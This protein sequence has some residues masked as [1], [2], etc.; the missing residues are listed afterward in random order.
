MS[1]KWDEVDSRQEKS[2]QQAKELKQFLMLQTEQAKI[3]QNSIPSI[4]ATGSLPLPQTNLYSNGLSMTSCLDIPSKLQSGLSQN[5]LIMDDYITKLR[6]T[7]ELLLHEKRARLMVDQELQ[8]GKY[9]ILNLNNQL[10][11]LKQQSQHDRDQM[12]QIVNQMKSNEFKNQ[13]IIEKL[14]SKIDNE[15]VKVH[16]LYSEMNSKSNHEIVNQQQKDQNYNLLSE[17]FNQLN[18]KFQNFQNN[19]QLNDSQISNQMKQFDLEFEKYHQTLQH[20]KNY[21]ELFNQLK[22]FID[23]NSNFLKQNIKETNQE[24]LNQINNEVKVRKHLQE[25]VQM[26]QNDLTNYVNNLISE[27]VYQLNKIINQQSLKFK[28]DLEHLTKTNDQNLHS[29][30][31][32]I[33]HTNEPILHNLNQKITSLEI[34]CNDFDQVFKT[35][36]ENLN[37]KIN[38]QMKHFHAQLIKKDEEHLVNI[39][40]IF[41]NFKIFEKSINSKVKSLEDILRIEIKTRKESDSQKY[42]IETETIQSQIIRLNN[43]LDETKVDGIKTLDLLNSTAEKITLVQNNFITNFEKEIEKLSKVIKSQGKQFPEMLHSL[44]VEILSNQ[45]QFEL[46]YKEETSQ[47]NFEIEEQKSQLQ[48]QTSQIEGF[49]NL[50]DQLKLDI[51]DKFKTKSIQLDSTFEAYKIEL[52]NRPTND[53][54]ET[55]IKELETK[56]MEGLEEV[57]HHIEEIQALQRGCVTIGQY[58]ETKDTI[59]TKCTDLEIKSIEVTYDLTQ[60]KNKLEAFHQEQNQIPEKIFLEIQTLDQ[61]CKLHD[62]ALAS[63]SSLHERCEKEINDLKSLTESMNT[64]LKNQKQEKLTDMQSIQSMIHNTKEQQK[65]I[66]TKLEKCDDKILHLNDNLNLELN[67]ISKK[68]SDVSILVDD[69]FDEYTKTVKDLEDVIQRNAESIERSRIEYQ[70]LLKDEMD[71]LKSKHVDLV[72][73]VDIKIH[74]KTEEMVESVLINTKS[75]NRLANAVQENTT[76]VQSI[77]KQLKS[78]ITANEKQIEKLR[79]W[80]NSVQQNFNQEDYL[81]Q[82]DYL[83]T[84]EKSNELIQLNIKEIEKLRKKMQALEESFS[85]KLEDSIALNGK[86]VSDS[87]SHTQQLQVLQQSNHQEHQQLFLEYQASIKEIITEITKI[88][89]T[90][91]TLLLDMS[92]M[93]ANLDRDEKIHEMDQNIQPIHQ[94]LD[95]LVAHLHQIE[96]RINKPRNSSRDHTSNE[97]VS[98]S[99]YKP[100]HLNFRKDIDAKDDDEDASEFPLKHQTSSLEF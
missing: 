30:E 96:E 89:K 95:S 6:T 67:S 56:Y 24:I 84:F 64:K 79:D 60:L 41:S 69:K 90:I 43:D 72:Q 85:K 94:K 32:K 36:N 45:D 35:M 26:N 33:Y 11:Q 7:E 61:K 92:K 28:Q 20:M 31:K 17:Q 93:S 98:G 44:K 40:S 49:Q 65:M 10:E 87:I 66:L 81:K 62:E 8:A 74:E 2:K 70:D 68:V 42:K 75:C 63:N 54:L 15:A 100:P 86:A 50:L 34:Q 46:Q 25:S 29:I 47:M 77:N 52:A 38:D 18:L 55:S 22:V 21:D 16:Q 9:L 48:I 58:E 57:N 14:N 99:F 82:K 23:S 91:N 27:N 19:H 88:K 12:N 76:M 73:S 37:T 39:Q 59:E 4:N 1:F 78:D 97:L 53:I 80:F 83:K 13:D 3:S 51:E 5:P 71:D